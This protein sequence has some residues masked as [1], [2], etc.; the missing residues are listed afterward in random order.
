MTAKYICPPSPPHCESPEQRAN[1]RMDQSWRGRPVVLGWHDR[2][3]PGK[4]STS[5]R[6]TLVMRGR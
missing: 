4:F 2:P 3:C 1:Q 6:A 5:R